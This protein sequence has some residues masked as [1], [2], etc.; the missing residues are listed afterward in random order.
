LDKFIKYLYSLQ[1]KFK[2]TA[3]NAQFDKNFV[4]ALFC[5]NQRYGDYK[6]LFRDG[7]CCVLDM[8]KTFIKDSKNHKLKTIC[9]YYKI[10]LINAH[11]A[12]ADIEA[13]IKV[14]DIL[15]TKKEQLNPYE[16][17]VTY[18]DKRKKYLQTSHIQIGKDNDVYISSIAVKNKEALLFI[19][20]ELWDLYGDD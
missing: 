4:Y 13:T 11:D 9:D 12:L 19:I 3:Y 5:R 2:F 14:Y 1:A 18:L 7:I 10:D 17:E 8:A 15:K 16:K 20:Q 6:E